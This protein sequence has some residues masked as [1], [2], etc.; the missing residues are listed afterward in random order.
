VRVRERAV[1]GKATHAALVALAAAVGVPLS[2]VTLVAGPRSRLKIVD[3]PDSA[4]TRI[5]SL[6]EPHL[7]S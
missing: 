5:A 1:D 2:D 3:V 6:R 4:A 7:R